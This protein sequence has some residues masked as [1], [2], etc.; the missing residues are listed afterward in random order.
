M[1]A[2]RIV[3]AQGELA[4]GKLG[5]ALG[6]LCDIKDTTREPEHLRQVHALA[7]EGLAKAGRFSRGAWKSLLNDTAEKL[8]SVE[9][10][11]ES[12]S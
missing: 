6:S 3:R 1:S 11:A 5:R 10:A 9:P 2:D 4:E 12:A 7:A 8:A